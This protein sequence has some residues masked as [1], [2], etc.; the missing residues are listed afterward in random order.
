[1]AQSLTA[2][3]A[4]SVAKSKRRRLTI[5]KSSKLGDFAFYVNVKGAD[6]IVRRKQA[7]ARLLEAYAEAT[8]EVER[9]GKSM[10]LR[11]TVAPELGETKVEVTRP[12]IDAL[13]AALARAETRGAETAARLLSADDMLSADQFAAMIEST[14]E[15][16]HQKRRRG[17]VLGLKGAKR[18]MR[19][20]IWQLIDGRRLLPVLPQLLAKF[21]SEPWAVY[22]FLL[23]AHA[24]LGGSSALDYLKA[25]RVDEVLS[26]AD[27]ITHGVHA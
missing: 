13:D 26:V 1:M 27:N 4:R 22:R 15:T 3:A 24:E 17:E 18:G 8:E 20:P 10:D 6:Q 12:A 14:R 11:I 19:F 7:L 21:D 5:R 9:T 23:Q 2:P 25:G 16:V